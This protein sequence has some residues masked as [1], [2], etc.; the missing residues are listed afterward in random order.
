MI[1]GGMSPL[2]IRSTYSAVTLIGPTKASHR[3]LTPPTSLPQ[4]PANL[5]A[6]PRV[7]SLPATVAFDQ[8]VGFGQQAAHR[9][10]AVIQVVLDFVEIAVVGIGDFRRDVAL[11]DPV[12]IFGRDVDRADEGIAQVIDAADQL[13]PAA[14]E[15]GCIAAGRQ[16]A[17]HRRLYQFVR[18][19]QQPLMVSMQLLRLFLISLKSP[20]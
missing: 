18:F 1:F 17:G 16:L 8:F 11:A 13:A 6:S 9:I 15:F 14:R 20:L 10:D 4:P 12:H 19:G 2:L 7:A 5:A 3:S